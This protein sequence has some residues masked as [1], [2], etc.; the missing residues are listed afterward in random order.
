MGPLPLGVSLQQRLRPLTPRRT[1][2]LFTFATAALALSAAEPAPKIYRAH[3]EP[4]WLG[5][6]AFWYRNDLAGGAREF[7]LVD[8]ATGQRTPA[9]DHARVPATALPI[10]ALEFSPTREAVILHGPVRSWRL[11]LATYETRED[12]GA[13]APLPPAAADSP[14]AKTSGVLFLNRSGDALCVH[15]IGAK[16]GPQPTHDLGST[17][18][19]KTESAPGDLWLV[20]AADGATR[21]ILRAVS[22]SLTVTIE[23]NNV[24]LTP[25]FPAPEPPRT[26]VRSPDGQWEAYVREHNLWLRATNGPAEHALSFDAG[27]AH[28]FHDDTSRDRLIGMNFEKPESP[29]TLPDVFWSPDSHYLLALQTRTVPERRVYLTESSPVDQLQPKLQRYVDSLSSYRK[30]R[31]GELDVETKRRVHDAWHRSFENWGYPVV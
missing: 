19:W 5:D 28:T 15:H 1:L 26:S 2:A 6:T 10:E 27:P 11:D 24:T 14:P 20:T 29:A 13:V 7:V 8:T 4:V 22:S 31:Y 23:K 9:F 12:R 18:R 21:T 3:V 30:N 17:A 25:S 16:S